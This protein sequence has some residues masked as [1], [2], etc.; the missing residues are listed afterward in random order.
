[1][2]I[3][4]RWVLVPLLFASLLLAQERPPQNVS[5]KG[6]L[7]ASSDPGE[8][9]RLAGTVYDAEG[10]NPMPGVVL[11]AYQTDAS[12]VYSKPVDDSRNPRL[13]GWVKTDS[14]GRFE[15]DT[16]KPGSYPGGGNPAHIHV[17]FMQGER[18]DGADEC[19]FE[20]DR[21]LTGNQKEREA[22]AGKFS[23]IVRLSKDKD[24]IW[25]GE[26]NLRRR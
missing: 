12:G 4:R 8:R 22:A 7:A 9:L 2:S 5:S 18:Q 23:R 24:G 21:Y 26:W 10:K 19:W 16:I 6:T 13:R 15:L 3:Q 14:S 1:M 25:R 11:F 20:G 17:V